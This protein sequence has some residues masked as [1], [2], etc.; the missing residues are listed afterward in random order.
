[1]WRRALAA[2]ALCLVLAGLSCSREP[3]F[4]AER[5]FADLV[6]QCDFGPRV[7][8][9]EAHARA[10]DFLYESLKA[11]TD[12]AR[13]Q[14]F[15][16]FDS[17]TGETLLLTNIIASYNPDNR[18][19]VLLCAHW[20]SRPR[21]E[22]EPDSSRQHLPVLGANDGA[23]GVAVLLEL[24]RLFAQ[25]APPVGVDIVLFDGEDYGV[26][27]EVHGWLIGSEYFAANLG[28][29]RPRLAIL[30]DMIADRDLQ[31][32]REQHSEKYAGQI[33]DYVWRIA[34]KLGVTAFVDSVNHAVYDDHIS[35]LAR[36]IPAIDIID[37]DY[38]HWHTQADTPD[39]CSPQSLAAVGRVLVAAVYNKA[40][41]N[42]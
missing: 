42:F 35:L 32:F 7:P 22:K 17:L 1:M 31:I 23:S 21:S 36:R 20:D 5:A 12:L 14:P 4:D 8:N 34:R 19:R 10:A 30:V 28:S 33:N 3:E 29:Y 27:G 41:A 26:S 15:T 6:A 16:Y 18:H 39:K 40:I 9:S 2:A 38:P 24:G 25:D 11:T 37:F 13:R